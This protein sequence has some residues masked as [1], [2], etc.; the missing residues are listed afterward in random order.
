MNDAGRD[1]DTRMRCSISS[2]Y[3]SVLE[4]LPRTTIGTSCPGARAVHLAWGSMTALLAVN[5]SILGLSHAKL[6][7]RAAV[8]KFELGTRRSKP[9]CGKGALTVPTARLHK[10]YCGGRP[11]CFCGIY[12]CHCAGTHPTT[13]RD[14]RERCPLIDEPTSSAR[15]GSDIAG[16]SGGLTRAVGRLVHGCGIWR[17]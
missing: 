7:I 3:Y 15:S 4:D 12:L 8:A 6:N 16:D 1:R 17:R 13:Y 9:S 10:L 2:I 5:G 11:D 14:K